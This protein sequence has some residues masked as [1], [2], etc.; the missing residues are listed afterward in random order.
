MSVEKFSALSEARLGLDWAW[1]AML[2]R[3]IVGVADHRRGGCSLSTRLRV[4]FV[5][6]FPLCGMGIE[7]G[8][9]DLTIA[10]AAARERQP[11]ARGE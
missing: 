4:R 6:L 11:L 1:D 9:A 2:L 10:P 5:L 3:Q 8:P 7:K